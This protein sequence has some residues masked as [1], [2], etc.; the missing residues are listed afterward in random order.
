MF[1]L[2]LQLV[3]FLPRLDQI[4]LQNQDPLPLEQIINCKSWTKFY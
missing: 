1:D 4:F 3:N 2:Q